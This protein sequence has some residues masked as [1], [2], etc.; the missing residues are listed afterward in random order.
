MFGPGD[1]LLRELLQ[2]FQAEASE[3][4]QTLN[5][6]L[7]SLEVRP[8]ESRRQELVS[9]AFR[10][11][12]S[13]K[14]AA[15]A[16]GLDTIEEL[17]H[18]MENV[19]DGA[20]NTRQHL[21][22][23]AYDGLYDILD[24]IGQVLEGQTVD[25]P[26]LVARLNSKDKPAPVPTEEQPLIVEDVPA[27]VEAAPDNALKEAPIAVEQ[28]APPAVAPVSIPEPPVPA[29]NGRSEASVAPARPPVEAKRARSQ[30][31]SAR[32]SA[33]SPTGETAPPEAVAA[34]IAVSSEETI[35]VAIA[36]L[37]NLMAQIG[38]L[39]VSK[40]NAED[41]AAEMRVIRYQFAGW[42]KIWREIKTLLPQVSGD[43]GRRLAEILMHYQDQ[44]QE[45]A[46]E[47]SHFDQ[48]LRQ[49]TLRL[50]IIAS[51][52]QDN[53]RHVRMVP[54]ETLVPGLQRAVRDAAHSERK[55][56]TFQVIG[57]DVELDKKVLET[58]KDPLLHMLRNAVS[59]GI[60]T[61]EERERAHKPAE[62][63]VT[64]A[65]Q[66]RGAEVR[67]TV[68]DDGKG[69]DLA[70]LRHA[71]SEK[72]NY[73]LDERASQDE[74]I[75]LAF[76]PGMTTSAQVTALS[77]RGVGLDIVRQRIEALQ[78]RIQVENN[79]GL[80]AIIHLLVP[81]TL[82]M[83]RGLLVQVGDERYVLPLLA[84]E[85]IVVPSQRFMLEG[86]TM[87]TVDGST[88]PLV[89]LSSLLERPETSL[90][91]VSGL[92]VI[93]VVAEQRLALLVDDVL[94]EQELAVKPLGKPLARVRN[95]AGAAVMGDGKPVVILNAADL[96][97][98]AKGARKVAAVQNLVGEQEKEVAHILVVDDSITTR[99][100]EK[101]ILETAGYDVTTAT[102]GREALRRIKE[103]H[104]DLVVSDVQM[105]NM[106]GIALTRTLRESGEFK[107]IPLILV[108][109]LE[110]RE[111]R[112]RGLVAG[113]NA[114]IV[115]R[116]FDQAE[117]LKT[118]QQLVFVEEA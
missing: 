60:E 1:D 18:A 8:E 54:F 42:P 74:V 47:V 82:T 36:K 89:P 93:M 97:K 6:T 103:Q 111:D 68:R 16:V 28:V 64:L 98:S 44:F 52:L 30:P 106:D 102:D 38:E 46:Q 96:V 57:G 67:I 7:L 94:T 65:L 108:T 53:V 76:L 37:D 33:D 91:E 51:Q 40:M 104:I 13:L 70:A 3:H 59:H 49:D 66:Q 43:A 39:L 48:R 4:L 9:E 105:P 22:A 50:G 34:P 112:E 26:T 85:K 80:G 71:G 25:I 117:L 14:G 11:A 100:L 88:L 27:P 118:V 32:K 107:D 79:P 113:A 115:K 10:A 55:Q 99:T 110:S 72:G 84:I 92:A 31:Q 15:R 2:T 114:Y 29:E 23:D 12:H 101:N 77:G 5:M 116:G 20:R 61:P 78:G 41:R 81:I 69:F 62:G 17:A 75:G 56:V 86:R 21:N 83:T 45:M 19:L 73:S 90:D 109:S 95:V 35:R 58:L 63:S 87:L 24:A